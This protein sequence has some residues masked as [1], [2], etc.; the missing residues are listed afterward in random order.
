MTVVSAVSESKL[1]TALALARKSRDKKGLLAWT[2]AHRVQL[3]DG[4]YF[5]LREHKYLREIYKQPHR[6]V[7]IYKAGQMGA[8]EY[9]VSR[10]LWSC[11]ELDATVLYIFPSATRVS[12]FSAARVGP[13]IDNSPYLSSIVGRGTDGK[14]GTDRV[15]LRQIRRRFLYMRG[16][17]VSP[18]GKAAQ[19][20]SVDADVVI[21][22][23]LDESDSRAPAIA[24]KRLGHSNLKHVVWVSTPSYHE[25]GIHAVYQRSD[26]REWFVP[27]PSCG[28]WQY[29]TIDHVVLEWDALKRPTAWNGQDEERAY[30]ACEKCHAELDRLTE[31]VWVP[32]FPGREL[33]GYHLTKFFGHT[34]ELLDIVNNLNTVDE[35][36]RRECYNQDLG[37]PYAPA[38]GRIT[39]E[40]L[41]ACQREYRA[42]VVKGERTFMGVDVGR[43]LHV[44]IR[45]KAGND[46]ERKLRY[47]VEVDTFREV[48]RL[49]KRFNVSRCVIDG[50]PETRKARE[51]QAGFRDGRIFLAYY[52]GGS[53]DQESVQH[54]LKNGTV[55]IDRTRSLDE[56]V[57]MFLLEENTIPVGAK[58]S[59]K[60]YYDQVQAPVRVLDDRP[61]AAGQTVAK[62]VETGADHFCH[63]ENYCAIAARRVKSAFP[64]IV[65]GKGTKGW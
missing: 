61:S 18:E 3:K 59:I 44:V 11:D 14:Y 42:G 20:K 23:E 36:S 41:D 15:T 51:L 40:M 28:H 63:A 12:D 13:A 17:S 7:V 34:N 43:L 30:A 29:M 62:Y 1:A 39:E 33:V 52:S 10:S 8:S 9:A 6:Q 37:L 65:I 64:G 19:L 47:A 21:F 22:D 5:D 48:A 53:K 35:T 38:G 2:A 24:L 55:T 16:A 58:H 45:T 31:G 27:C 32:E 50:L 56:L 26:Q 4:V 54:N 57:S 49:I 46:G 60:N 25:R